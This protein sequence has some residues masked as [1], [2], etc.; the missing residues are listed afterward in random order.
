MGMNFQVGLF[1]LAWV[2]WVVIATMLAI[3]VV[4]LSFARVR[5]WIWSDG[6]AVCRRGPAGRAR[7]LDRRGHRRA[8]A[9]VRE[10]R[11]AA[12]HVLGVSCICMYM[13]WW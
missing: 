10:G 7:P 9:G 2:F 1:D 8:G 6:P 3:A 13:L 5:N 4:V 12:A 11:T